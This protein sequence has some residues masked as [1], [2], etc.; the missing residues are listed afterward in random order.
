M[1]R[2]QYG[3]LHKYCSNADDS[4][5]K[6]EPPYPSALPW[7]VYIILLTSNNTG[8]THTTTVITVCL[9]LPCPALA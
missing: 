6:H 3:R 8:A 7:F 9:A 5:P 1:L 4:D 2:T